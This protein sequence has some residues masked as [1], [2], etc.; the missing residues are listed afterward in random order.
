MATCFLW[1][2]LFSPS[3]Q[4]HDSWNICWP[5]LPAMTKVVHRSCHMVEKENK[6]E[7]GGLEKGKKN[8]TGLRRKILPLFLPIPNAGS[9]Q[10]MAVF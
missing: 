9:Q 7:V 8:S 5:T 2:K 3:T 4:T 6:S 1:N 10:D